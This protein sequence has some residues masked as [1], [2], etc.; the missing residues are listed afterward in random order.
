[1]HR[2]LAVLA[3]A[4]VALA[5]CGISTSSK[6]SSTSSK[7]CY[8]GTWVGTDATMRTMLGVTNEP[9][10]I[11]TGG[12]ALSMG[13]DGTFS[14]AFNNLGTDTT[15]E[16]KPAE[17]SLNGSVTG[18]YKKATQAFV[19]TVDSS[20]VTVTVDG[21]SQK[22]NIKIGSNDKGNGSVGETPYT[23]GGN[24]LSLTGSNDGKVTTW[25]RD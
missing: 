14:Y 7:P 10:A 16:G 6:S 3:F 4:T 11:L 24:Q 18:T 25:T 20:D 2:K 8:V 5:G 22:G 19:F 13:D 23:C 17:V 12:V 15:S 9:D 21:K 1:M